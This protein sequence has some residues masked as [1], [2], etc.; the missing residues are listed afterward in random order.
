MTM[1]ACLVCGYPAGNEPPWGADGRCPTYDICPCCGCEFG[2]E[3]SRASGIKNYREAWIAEGCQWFDPKQKPKD[4]KL[5]D[6][7]QNIPHTLPAGIDHNI[8][9]WRDAP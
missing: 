6:Q 8:S 1:F 5:D 4:W 7:I 2:Y 9:D 3:D